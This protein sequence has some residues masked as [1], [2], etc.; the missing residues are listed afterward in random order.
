MLPYLKGDVVVIPDRKLAS[1][2]INK[3]SYGKPSPGGSS[4]LS[5]LE[6][7]YLLESDRLDVKRS[8]KG[9]KASHH[10][11]LSRGISSQSRFME[12][13]LVFRDIRNRGINIQGGGDRTFMSYP[14]GQ[15]PRKGRA[16]SW[17]MVFREHDPVT[18]HGL[19]QESIK[20]T[21][22]RM[23]LIS[24]VVDGD[25]D[26]TYYQVK[27]ALSNR[28][29]S[30]EH[31]TLT[32]KEEDHREIPGG[33]MLAWEGELVSF[34][35]KEGMGS[36]IHDTLALSSQE[37]NWLTGAGQ[38]DD[39][40]LKD[41]VYSDLVDMGYL[42]KTGFKYGSHFRVYSSGSIDEHS[43][44]LVHCVDHAQKFTWEELSRAIR[45]SHSVKK[46]MLFAILEK[47]EGVRYLEIEWTRP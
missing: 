22:M 36:D 10:D 7:A 27:E 3:G 32:I 8:R 44:L 4:E 14:R 33:G 42:V 2:L 1:T 9:R 37:A 20:R 18:V 38:V 30:V 25:W 39:R 29:M 41:A 28:E 16:D 31:D 11:L 13:Y 35:R 23:D 40:S 47:G 5:L 21:G 45:L 24:A 43:D 46:R 34:A 15:G 19:L 26:L 12:N 6:A 17:I